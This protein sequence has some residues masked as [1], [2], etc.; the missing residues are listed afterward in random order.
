[1]EH[2]R[3]GDPSYLL[4]PSSLDRFIPEAEAWERA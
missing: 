2:G 1:V 4:R 3:A